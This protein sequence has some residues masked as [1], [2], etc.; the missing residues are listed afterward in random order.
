[1]RLLMTTR[2]IDEQD[3]AAGFAVR[4]VRT[5][6][7]H[8]AQLTIICQEYGPT[9][10]PD[11]VTVRSMGKEQ[12]RGRIGQLAAFYRAAW[13][14]VPRHDA[15][16]CHMIP[17]YVWLIAPLARLHRKRITFWYIHRNRGRELRAALALVDRI[18]T[19]VPGTFPI[20]SAKVTYV[21]HGV[22]TAMFSPAHPRAEASPPQV[23]LLGR[24]SPIKH[25]YT[26][27]EAAALLEAQYGITDI[28]FTI[29]G[30]EP[31]EHPS[32][33]ASLEDAIKAHGLQ[34]RF[35][36]MG[37]VSYDAVPAIYR[38]AAVALNLAPPGLFDKAALEAMLCGTPTIVA[39][40]AF[41]ALLGPHVDALRIGA[42]D[43]VEGLAARLAPLLR[44][45]PEQRAQIGADLHAA[46][47]EAHGLD[48]LMDRLVQLFEES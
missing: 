16:F 41:D 19:A 20:A 25:H 6:A 43:D 45:T 39:N 29:V 18:V 14:E 33:R 5:L 44:A 9:N 37:A 46:T 36:F 28:T 42:P 40:P 26:M 23:V 4:W 8:V 21:G 17:R 15:V 22:D 34:G 27:I 30:G 24:L 32:Y 47:R 1:M 7:A 31:P 2:K 10:L 38:Q 13:R 11:N 3:I 12:G 35:R 48:R